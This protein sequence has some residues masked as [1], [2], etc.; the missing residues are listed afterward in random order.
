MKKRKIL[1]SGGNGM[2][3][4][5]INKHNKDFEMFLLSKDEMNVT[6]R[7]QI[8]KQISIYKPDIFLHSA[9]MT[10]P[11]ESHVKNPGESIKNNILGTAN[12]VISCA[13]K[14]IK[15][16]YI[17]TDWVYPNR[18]N[19]TE[20]D[21]LFPV[22][23]YGWS[24]LGGE[25]AVHMISDHLILRCSFT[26]RPYKF[27]KAFVDVYKSYL[28][29]DEIAPLII[30]LIAKECN[31]VYNVCG[32][33]KTAYSFAKESNPNV[34]KINRKKAHSWIPEKCTMNNDKTM[35]E[36]YYEPGA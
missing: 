35:K 7:D 36:I 3:A 14:N 5:E 24:K 25:C 2:L 20:K 30:K 10:H 32:G 29:I 9:A 19:N 31:G 26:A 28:Y 11:M 6:D 22:T 23:N 1:V 27:D 33:A 16:V 18:M 13:D 34:G 15:M 8:E 12:V 17:S 21:G 4:Q